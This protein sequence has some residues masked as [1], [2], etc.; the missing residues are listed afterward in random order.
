MELARPR[1]HPDRLDR[2][3]ID[4]NDDDVARGLTG[5]LVGPQV[6]EGIFQRIGDP[7]QQNCRESAHDKKMRSILSHAPHS[8]TCAA[9]NYNGAPRAAPSRRRR[10]NPGLGLMAAPVRVPV[11]VSVSRRVTDT[12]SDTVSD[13][14]A[15]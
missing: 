5:K 7:G 10:V 6:G 1:P 4:R 13:A 9:F 15:G 12:V 3:G 8:P 11:S 2:A 14:V